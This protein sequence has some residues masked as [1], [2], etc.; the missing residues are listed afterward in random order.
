VFK[1]TC[2]RSDQVLRQD[3]F[4]NIKVEEANDTKIFLPVVKLETELVIDEQVSDCGTDNQKPSLADI[5]D[6]GSGDQKE[7]I[8]S[9]V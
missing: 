7:E 9:S 3:L 2:I 5:E 6:T 4:V 8:V 1:D